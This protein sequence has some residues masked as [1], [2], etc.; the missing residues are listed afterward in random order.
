MKN[1]LEVFIVSSL[2]SLSFFTNSTGNLE[3]HKQSF[4]QLFYLS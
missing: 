3:K 1:D 2:A 4:F